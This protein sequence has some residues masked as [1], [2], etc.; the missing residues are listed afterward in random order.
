MDTLIEAYQVVFPMANTLC[1]ILFT[2]NFESRKA[3][4]DYKQKK[5]QA[6]YEYGVSIIL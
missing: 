4:E 2:Q 6:L 3:F 1:Q 5:I